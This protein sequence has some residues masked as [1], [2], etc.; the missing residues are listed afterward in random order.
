MISKFL[1]PAVHVMNKLPFKFKIIASISV[2]FLLLIFP[3]RTTF[4]MYIVKSETYEKQL[5][6]LSYNILIHNLIQS[7][8]MHRGLSNGYLNGNEIFKNRI[9][10]IEKQIDQRVTLLID[11]DDRNLKILKHNKK[12]VSSLGQLELIYLDR[13]MGEISTK[14]IFEIHSEIISLLVNTFND[15]SALTTF[16]NSDDKKINYISQMLK[17]KNILLQEN[18]A[19]LRGLAVGYFAQKS[20]LKEEKSK[21]L[22]RYA[23][24]K[25]LETSILENKDLISMDNYLQIEKKTVHAS[26]K[27]NNLLDI[28]NKNIMMIEKPTYDSKLFFKQATSAIAEY[29]K[30]YRTFVINYEKLVKTSRQEMLVGF[31]LTL[32]GFFAIMFFAFYVFGAFYSSVARSL[33]KL[34]TASEMIAQGET[35][36]YLKAD[37]KDEIGNAL[38]AFNEMSQKLGENIAFLD[39]YKMAIDETS[40]VSKTNTKGVI[41]YANKLFCELSGYS[42]KELIG[43][44]HNIVRHPDMPKDAFKD[45]WKTIK[46][47]KIWKGVVKNKTKDGVD[48]IVDATIIPVLNSHGEIVEYIGVRHDITELENSK[49]EIQKQKIDILTGLPNRNQLLDDLEIAKEPILLYLNIDDFSSLNDFYGSKT[50]DDVLVHVSELLS[51]ISQSINSK[52]YRLHADEFLLLVQEDKLTSKNCQDAM[53]EIINYVEMQ[54][55]DCDSKACISITIS[56]GVSFYDLT[57]NYEFLLS[58]AIIARKAAKS[59]N[60]KFLRYS[61]EMNK[62]SDYQSNIDWINK[63]KDAIKDDRIT[64]FFQPIIDNESGAIT[65]YE[66]LVRMIDTEDKVISPF[67]FLDIAKKAKLYTQITKIVIDKTFTTFEKLPQYDFSM[68]IT[69][70]DVN[71]ENIASYIFEKLENFPH[72]HRVILEITESE[73]IKDY[74]FINEFIEKVK[75]FG[76]KIAIDDFGSGYANFEHIISLNADFIKIDGSLIKNIDKDDNSQIITEAII[77]FSKKLGSKTVV[78]FVHNQEVYEKVKELGAD[79]SQGFYL[80]EPKPSPVSIKELVSKEG[81]PLETH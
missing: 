1:S 32:V 54:T 64:T 28:V 25:S 3:T 78:E 22:Y 80:G 58:Y 42:E 62:D 26:H 41:T 40:I 35:D 36:I 34:Q 24:I 23:L 37:T 44:S 38:L 46:A 76:A 6:G 13:I 20:I 9:Y 11:F 15:I 68:N 56:G 50:G 30:L 75:G 45:M 48:Y 14:T 61:S 55:V 19:Q 49:L 27:L 66:A 29:N 53:D 8:Q 77:A 81:D 65:K 73:E 43:V 51:E 5:V 33:K 67:F 17:E 71:D 21:L 7:I 70:E 72:S 60:K 69:V 52:L 2:L 47:K 39:S 10:N 16:T 31:I 79:Y 63:I 59:E 74:T 57:D 12:F 4:T 18:M